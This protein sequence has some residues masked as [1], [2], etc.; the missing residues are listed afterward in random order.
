MYTLN[1]QE[2]RLNPPIVEDKKFENEDRWALH[3]EVAAYIIATY[4]DTHKN[5][6]TVERLVK[7]AVRAADGETDDDRFNK[8][9]KEFNEKLEADRA[10]RQVIVDAISAEYA[11][12][13][14]DLKS[15]FDNEAEKI[16]K[17]YVDKI[18][19]AKPEDKETLREEQQLKLDDFKFEHRKKSDALWN[20]QS[21]KEQ[22]AWHAE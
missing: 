14:A 21:T 22:E 20:E 1:L 17:E 6:V 5:P 3:E 10:E 11:S 4:G 15:W 7:K 18:F 16:I 19:A 13:N 12:K 8:Q 2:V 9:D